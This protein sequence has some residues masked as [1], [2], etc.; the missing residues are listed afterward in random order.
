VD[1]P[2]RLDWRCL[3]RHRS[4]RL[5]RPNWTYRLDRRYRPDRLDWSRFDRYR[6]NGLDRSYWVDWC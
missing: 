5:D 4:Y 3:Y 6:S 2:Y 1:R